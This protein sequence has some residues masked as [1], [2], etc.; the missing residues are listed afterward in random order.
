MIDSP[1]NVIEV[2]L[3]GNAQIVLTLSRD[4]HCALPM[5]SVSDTYSS[6]WSM[7]SGT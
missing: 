3:I 1:P 7:P 6:N 4:G 5:F 2:R